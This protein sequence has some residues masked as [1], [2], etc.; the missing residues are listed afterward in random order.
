MLLV[1]RHVRRLWFFIAILGCAMI[2][3]DAINPYPRQILKEEKLVTW[4]FDDGIAGWT[5]QHN[6]RVEHADGA[7]R[8]VGT[9]NDPYC[10]GPEINIPGPVLMK[11]RCR[12]TGKGGAV[13]YWVPQ[14]ERGPSQ[15]RHTPIHV[16]DDDKWHEY[17]VELPVKGALSWIRIDPCADEGRMD[18]D[19]IELWRIERHPL[20]I[21][22]VRVEQNRIVASVRNFSEREVRFKIRDGEHTVGAD[23]AASVTMSYELKG[24]R[25]FEVV[26]LTATVEGLPPVTRPLALYNPAAT[27]NWIGIGADDLILQVAPD[28]TGARLLRKEQPVAFI[29]PLVWSDG[30]TWPLHPVKDADSIRVEGQ[31][32]KRFVFTVQGDEIQVELD[33]AHPV[34]GPVV[35]ALGG[36]EQGLLAG[37]EYLGKGERSSS[38]L[39][40]EGPEHIR[41]EPDPMKLTM[42]FMA[43]VTDQG[44]VAM[45]WTNMELQPTFATPNF[46][47]GASDH[48]M[49]LK[50]RV[51]EAT[52]RVGDPFDAGN[53]LE[54]T[55]LWAVIKR[56]G[57]PDL[58]TPPRTSDVQMQFCLD[59]LR[60]S[61]V[62]D[63]A[64]GWYH[65]V[66]PG[67]RKMPEKPKYFADA[68]STIW[69]ISGEV[70]NV[71]DM[72]RGGA[73]IRNDSIYFVTGR[74]K[75]WLDMMNR[76]A[77]GLIKAQQP[78][79]AYRYNGEYQKGHFEDTSS[80]WCAYRAARLLDHAYYTGNEESLQAGIRTLDYMKR[81]RTPRGA[82]VWECPLHS[83]DLLA[84]AH[85][86]WAYVRGYELTK[87]QDYLDLALRWAVT[88]IPFVYQ[89]G[90]QPIMLYA[91]TPILC[92]THW[93]APVWIGLPVQ[94]V[95]ID[96]AYALLMLQEHDKSFDW[97][98][99]AEGILIAGEQMQYPDGP[100]KGCLPDVFELKHQQRR[101]ADI[102]PCAL[103]SLRMRIEGRLD[104]LSVS[105]DGT[106]RVVSPFPVKIEDGKAHVQSKEGVDYQVIIDGDR[107]VDAKSKGVD[108]IDLAQ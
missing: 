74:A 25:P 67:H 62:A 72:V 81:F 20:A 106:H 103:A 30:K 34:E 57:L 105:S 83:P 79:G 60:N 22:D 94:W 68:L 2:H 43:F 55:I 101:P 40:I 53:Q 58:P 33:A 37:V 100:S 16:Q 102:N 95:G 51:I 28:G 5:A 52:I 76:E 46:Y 29:A 73:H 56:G 19:W 54:N 77:Q 96:Y 66:V 92:A 61:V 32:I 84:S 7:L 17:A 24:D 13:I 36:I 9:G 71:P 88:G 48:R 21:E 42:P 93:K 31:N 91:T 39:D 11:L 104:N 6:C 82:Q 26:G 75:Q 107:I 65:A 87:N 108:V 90:N 27:A 23:K 41:N 86:V 8:I 38:T 98:R 44:S 1:F 4:S 10:R 97:R 14:G 78:D 12:S 59:A 3:A 18:I 89:W 64:G 45:T 99:L 69:R 49:S 63:P 15:E 80:G 50:G 70:R 35:R 47:D 85:L